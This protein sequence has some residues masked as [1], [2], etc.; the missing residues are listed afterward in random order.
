M[1]IHQVIDTHDYG[2]IIDKREIF[3][4]SL[5]IEEK[6]I[7]HKVSNR[8][9]KNIRIL[10]N[11]SDKPIIIHQHSIGGDWFEGMMI[12]DAIKHSKCYIAMIMHGQACSMGSLIPQAADL[13]I[14]MP[15]TLFMTHQGSISIS[16]LTIKQADSLA[17]SEKHL[18]QVMLDIYAERCI[19]GHFFKDRKYTLN[20]VKNYLNNKW[21]KFEDWYLT[22]LE[23]VTY[24]FCDIVL[25]ESISNIK[26]SILD[27]IK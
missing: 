3:L 11:I 17:N 27:K 24:G 6:G 14:I 4:H 15:N 12:F 16:D 7:D 19:D 21:D 5:D 25:N 10:E 20:R 18:R 26:K 2:I 9:L 13:R 22:P 1:K 8:F 23:S